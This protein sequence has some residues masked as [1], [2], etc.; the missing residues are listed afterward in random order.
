MARSGPDPTALLRLYVK[1]ER[2]QEAADLALSFLTHWQQQ[3]G[4]FSVLSS[5]F[6]M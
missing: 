3:V 5:M 2:L 1:H 6:T 4:P